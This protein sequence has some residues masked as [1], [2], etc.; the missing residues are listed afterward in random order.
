[1]NRRQNARAN[2]KC[3]QQGQRK[4]RDGQQHGPG[5]ETA[6][7]FGDCQRMDQRSS[8]KPGHERRVFNWIPK[9]PAAP[10]Q[11]V[12]GPPA[13][14]TDTDGQKHPCNVGPRARPPGPGRIKIATNQGRNGKGKGYRKTDITHVQQGRVKNHTRVLQQRI[15]VSAVRGHGEKT[16]EGV[17]RG[18]RKK[19]EAHADQAH[20]RK[21][22]RQNRQG[23]M[24]TEARHSGH[25][26]RQ[27]Q[28]PKQKRPLMPTPHRGYAELQRQGGIGIGC[29][30]EHRKIVPHKGCG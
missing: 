24:R 30:I 3:T 9:P 7:L 8:N 20:D 6:P 26:A 2:Q 17:G 23:Q 19:Q 10:T 25:P 27:H 13:A 21:H 16:L 14:Q 22:A 5:L 28:Q 29:D 1:M 12:V 11:L 4:S 15:E 18:E